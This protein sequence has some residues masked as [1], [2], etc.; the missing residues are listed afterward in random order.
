MRNVISRGFT[1]LEMLVVLA[2]IAVMAGLALPNFSRL[3]DSF[4]QKNQWATLEREIGDIPYQAFISGTSFQLNNASARQRLMGLP[5]DW[6]TEI[7]S[8]ITYRFSGW[9]EGGRIAV[10]AA[11]GERRDYQL[12][13]PACNPMTSSS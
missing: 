6:R 5:T 2:L 7:P 8:P 10:I 1:L 13:A 4:S 3:L 9:C 11:N 12:F